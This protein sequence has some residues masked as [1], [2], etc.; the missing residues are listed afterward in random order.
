MRFRLSVS[1]RFLPSF[2]KNLRSVSGF[3]TAFTSINL[4]QL[5]QKS[6]SMRTVDNNAS[7]K[8]QS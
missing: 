1:N 4:L 7:N 8:E 2:L 3:R 6:K 5:S